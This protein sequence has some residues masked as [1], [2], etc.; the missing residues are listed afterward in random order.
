MTGGDEAHSRGRCM[1]RGW[2]RG[3]ALA[4]TGAWHPGLPLYGSLKGASRMWGVARMGEEPPKHTISRGNPSPV[5]V[6]TRQ[7]SQTLPD[8]Q[9][10]QCVK[11]PYASEQD[12]F[13]PAKRAGAAVAQRSRPPLGNAASGTPRAPAGRPARLDRP[14]PALHQRQRCH[15]DQHRQQ[16]G[17]RRAAATGGTADTRVR[18]GRVYRASEARLG[19]GGALASTPAPRALR[20]RPIVGATAPCPQNHE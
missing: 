17:S 16:R 1:A 5:L 12:A 6:T 8:A 14:E 4:D 18:A 2:R 20:G 9:P 19:V 11:G 10:R 7:R 13:C 15:H 3:C